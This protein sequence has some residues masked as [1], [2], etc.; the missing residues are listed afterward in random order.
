MADICVNTSPEGQ[1]IFFK[2]HVKK[3]EGLTHLQRLTLQTNI[4]DSAF[5]IKRGILLQDGKKPD[6][7]MTHQSAPL[8]FLV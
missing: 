4:E 7:Q 3:W 5:S 2:N 8:W 6:P 1:R